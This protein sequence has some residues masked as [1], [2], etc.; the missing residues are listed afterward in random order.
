MTGHIDSNCPE[1]VLYTSQS[2][3]GNNKSVLLIEGKLW[4]TPVL[5]SNAK[6]TVPGLDITANRL[7]GPAP[8]TI[9]YLCV[10]EIKVGSVKGVLSAAE[11]STITDA[12]TSFRVNFSDIANA[13]AVE[14]ALPSYPD[15]KFSILFERPGVLLIIKLL[16]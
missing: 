10:W 16:R 14:Y 4:S 3:P 15:G 9:T 2:K 7:F 11:A 12:I 1:K 5:D 13:P 8:R 6:C